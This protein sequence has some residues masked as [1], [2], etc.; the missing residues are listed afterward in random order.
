MQKHDSIRGWFA[1]ELYEQMKKNDKVILVTADLGYKTFDSIRDELPN[2]FLNTGASEQ[3]GLAI[4]VGL[5]LQGFIPF[6]Y[7]ITPFALW[8]PA[9]VIRLYINHEKISV[10]ICGSG[11][12][13]D[14]SH[15]GFTHDATDAKQFLNQ[16]ENIKQ[17]WLDTKEEIPK[18]V[19]EMIGNDLPCFLSLRR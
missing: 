13:K 17:Y 7:S 5:A 18:I 3:A 12:D 6:F 2:Q 16:F 14:Y 4:C 10:K 8:R 1:Y 15:D 19:E 9:E 11:R